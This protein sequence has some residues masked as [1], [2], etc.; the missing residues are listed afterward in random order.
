MDI[1]DLLDKQ[2]AKYYRTK[3]GKK[4]FL[5]GDKAREVFILLKGTI[6]IFDS[7]S[8]FNREM[9]AEKISSGE[10]FG[11]GALVKEK[12][13]LYSSVALKKSLYAGL[14][15]QDFEYLLGNSG[16]LR[17]KLFAALSRRKKKL[18]QDDYEK[19][20]VE[21]K[22]KLPPSED[23][24]VV[25][26]GENE[27]SSL[28]EWSSDYLPM[29]GIYLSGHREIREEISSDAENFAKYIFSK[30]RKCPVCQAEIEV[31]KIRKSRL[32]LDE[33]RSDL[34]QIYSNFKP[35]WYYIWTCPYCFYTAPKNDFDELCR[36]NESLLEKKF[37]DVIL[38]T[39]DE[40]VKAGYSVPR[41]LNE[42]FRAYYTALRLFDFL[43]VEHDKPGAAWI[44]LSWLYEDA[45]FEK[46]Q[47]K[48]AERALYHLEKFYLHG[49]TGRLSQEAEHRIVLMLSDL[50]IKHDEKPERALKMLDS[51]IRADHI[52]RV[53]RRLAREKFREL[54]D[55]NR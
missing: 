54:K 40:K 43:E 35:S 29:D 47:A 39:E 45:G 44:R 25:S 42:V 6:A 26:S 10:I 7:Q 53:Y 31:R 51:L 3:Q 14:E 2:K 15:A 55:K 41:K 38:E 30:T 28:G 48:A 9:M 1:K 13:H 5:K 46:L 27:S 37:K 36:K 12:K 22:G 17:E 23:S 52:K 18:N 24:R 19:V 49:D 50:I 34:R 32:S 21:L 8:D 11:E 16:E 20:I 4:I 33:M